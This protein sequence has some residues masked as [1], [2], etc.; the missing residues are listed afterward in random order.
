MICEHIIAFHH[1]H[2]SYTKKQYLEQKGRDDLDCCGGTELL[3]YCSKC[4]K[5]L[6]ATK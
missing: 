1:G 4:G 6:E 3:S 2:G 5:K